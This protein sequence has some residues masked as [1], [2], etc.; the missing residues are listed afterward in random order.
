MN[1]EEYYHI[2]NLLENS[3]TF[4]YQDYNEEDIYNNYRYNIETEEK[5]FDKLTN[6]EPKEMID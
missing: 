1:Q 6:Y 3:I 2:L 4:P 5:Y